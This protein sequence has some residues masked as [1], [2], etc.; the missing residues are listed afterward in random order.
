MIEHVFAKKHSERMAQN[1]ERVFGKLEPVS[2]MKPNCYEL[3][4]TSIRRIMGDKFYEMKDIQD[5][6]LRLV[7][8]ENGGFNIEE[9]KTN[10]DKCSEFISYISCW[11]Q[12][13]LEANDYKQDFSPEFLD[14]KVAKVAITSPDG[15]KFREISMNDIKSMS[16]YGENGVILGMKNIREIAQLS[17]ELQ[18]NEQALQQMQ[19]TGNSQA[20][21]A[22]ISQ[23]N[24]YMNKLSVFQ[25]EVLEAWHALLKEWSGIEDVKTIFDVTIIF[26]V[27]TKSPDGKETIKQSTLYTYHDGGAKAVSIITK[28]FGLDVAIDE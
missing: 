26:G 15:I 9:F 22:M 13:F 17:Q 11:Y 16:S 10:I 24:E 28:K 5:D 8:F 3:P 19:Q 20:M 14:R 4:I 23:R 18:K 7:I 27:A 2:K 25:I 6:I 12:G 1:Y 21:Q